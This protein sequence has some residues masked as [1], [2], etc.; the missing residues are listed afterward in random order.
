VFFPD[1]PKQAADDSG[2]QLRVE[3]KFG[4]PVLPKLVHPVSGRRGNVVAQPRRPAHC[5]GKYK[6]HVPRG[7]AAWQ[8]NDAGIGVREPAGSVVKAADA[9]IGDP[10]SLPPR[11]GLDCARPQDGDPH[12]VGAQ[13]RAWSSF[14]DSVFD[15]GGPPKA[16]PSGWIKQEEEADF[17]GVLVELRAEWLEIVREIRKRQ[18]PLVRRAGHQQEDP[19]GQKWEAAPA[20][21]QDIRFPPERAC[22]N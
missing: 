12:N 22:S 9:R 3:V 16:D 18:V 6:V 1:C 7:D 17:A 14:E 4:G 8:L 13:V 2:K 11:G 20:H 21:L 19:C 10:P 5:R 15:F